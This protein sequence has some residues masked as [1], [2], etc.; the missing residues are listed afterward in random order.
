MVVLCICTPAPPPQGEGREKKKRK[1]LK[2]LFKT[3]VPGLPRQPLE[4]KLSQMERRID[5]ETDIY[6]IPSQVKKMFEVGF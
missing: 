3:V 1:K 6:A 2:Y 4:K 5:P